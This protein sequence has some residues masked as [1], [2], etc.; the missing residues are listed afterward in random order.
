VTPPEA[1]GGRLPPTGGAA[2]G[3][4]TPARGGS[5]DFGRLLARVRFS[6]CGAWAPRVDR[7]CQIQRGYGMERD[8]FGL[9]KWRVI[10]SDDRVVHVV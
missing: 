5:W 9:L 3:P 10:E 1:P 2:C 6:V 7:R 4:G 8:F